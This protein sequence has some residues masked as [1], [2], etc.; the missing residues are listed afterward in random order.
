MNR[1]L[2][3]S[4]LLL[5]ALF[6]PLA[7]QAAN[8]TTDTIARHAIVIEA[9]TGDILLAKDAEAAMPTSSM[10]KLLTMYLVFEA[11]RDGKLAAD[12]VVPTSIN[13][14]QQEGSRMF[15]NV[16]QA[17]RVEDLMRGVII[18]SGNDAAVSLAEAVGGTE[19]GFAV[20]MNRKAADLGMSK[21]HFVNATGLPDPQHY[22]T[23][24]D[25][26]RLALSLMR[27]FPQHYHYYSEREFTYNNIKQDNRNPLLYR[28]IGVDGIK[29]GHTEEAGYGL[30]A[31]SL[32]D[33]RRLVLVVNG[34]PNM[35]ARADESARLLDWAYREY[36][37]YPLLK[38]GEMLEEATVWLGQS[39]KVKLAAAT[40]AT[41]GLPRTARKDLR[42]M[43]SFTQ[44]MPA[45]LAAG[46]EVGKI[47]ITMPGR[48]PITVPLVTIEAVEEVGFFERL[49]RRVQILF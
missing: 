16:G 39:E 46:Q 49:N 11:L 44:P 36:G 48:E 8:P 18:Q 38:K 32:R 29:T 26:A 35:Q 17:V 45:P 24:Y 41:V 37:L 4:C 20:L 22:S 5:A 30:I 2:S 31:S 7:V 28:N 43:L 1:M 6:L 3:L 15:I 47:T 19:G 13:A 27:D 10:S 34:L 14:R 12:A 40:D 9:A 33:G 23:A 42:V 25:L 21:S